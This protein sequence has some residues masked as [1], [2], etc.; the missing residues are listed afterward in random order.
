M[1]ICPVCKNKTDDQSYT[2]CDNDCGTIYSDPCNCEYYEI[3]GKN[4]KRIINGHNPNCGNSDE[5]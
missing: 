2:M 1:S 4:G 3:K 5:Y